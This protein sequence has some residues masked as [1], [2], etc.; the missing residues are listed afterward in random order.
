MA[1][2]EM[3]KI[4]LGMCVDKFGGLESEEEKEKE[5]EDNGD[6]DENEENEEEGGSNNDTV[7]QT[8]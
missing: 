4:I 6:E 1:H 2:A 3:K 8:L 5:E 7:H